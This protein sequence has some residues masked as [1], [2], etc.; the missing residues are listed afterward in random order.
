MQP[1]ELPKLSIPIKVPKASK[2]SESHG[3]GAVHVDGRTIPLSC[4]TADFMKVPSAFDPIVSHKS[5][6]ERE[7]FVGAAP[8]PSLVDHRRDG[9]EGKIREQGE[10]GACTAFSLASTIDHAIARNGGKAGDIAVLHLWSR[11]ATGY[12]EDATATNLDRPIAPELAWP[13]DAKAACR[14]VASEDCGNYCAFKGAKCGTPDKD[15]RA[16]ADAAGVAKLAS[17]T[18]VK[19]NTETIVAVLA[20]GQDVWFGMALDAPTFE[21]LKGKDVVS[22]DFDGRETGAGHAMSIVGYRVQDSKTFFLLKNSWGTSW[23]DQGY[24]WMHEDTL[25]R[26]ADKAFVVETTPIGIAT[27]API[28]SALPT[29]IPTILPT[30]LPTSPPTTP[31]PKPSSKPSASSPEPTAFPGIPFPIPFPFTPLPTSTC[32]KGEVP[33]AA[34]GVCGKPCA[35]GSAPLGG[36]CASKGACPDGYV[37]LFGLCVI[38]PA[39]RSGLASDG[40]TYDCGLGGCVYAIPK[41]ALGCKDL[42]CLHV[43]PSPKFIASFGPRGLGCTE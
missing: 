39:K 7:G 35:D 23:G 3:C 18:R 34:S 16:K 15:A 40:V 26:N 28:P 29:A 33:D 6:D 24:A 5:F 32:K 42:V 10:V 22:P 37:E 36:K 8:L 30:T 13:Y 31:P 20:K 9:T 11:Y 17:V 41:G 38:S 12:K 14:W 1:I 27:P 25:L 4:R 2:T 19:L 21:K 43:C